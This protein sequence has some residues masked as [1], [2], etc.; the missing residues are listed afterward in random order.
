MAKSRFDKN[1]LYSRSLAPPKGSF[2]L[3][4]PRGCGKSTWLKE[5]FGQ[6]RLISLLDESLY[7]SYL[8]NPSLFYNSVRTE[9]PGSWVAVD[10]VQ[11]LPSLLNEVHRLI[12]DQKLKFV[13]TGSS[14]RKLRRTGVN[15]LAGRAVRRDMYPLTPMEMGDDFDLDQ[16]LKFGTLPLI[17][18]SEDPKDTLMSYVQMY[19]KE[20]IQAEA[21]VKNLSG[22][23][24][25]LPVAALF[26]GQ[27]LNMSNVARDAEV[28]R[29]TVKGFFDILEDTLLAKKLPAF[30]SRLR[31]REKSRSKFYWI[32]PG[33]VRAA[34]KDLN[35]VNAEEM[36]TLFEGFIHMLLCFQKDTYQDIDEIY[37]WSPAET[38]LTE[39]DFLLKKGREY[40]AIEVKSS[41][42]LRTEHLKGLRAISGL[43]GIK[44]K[45]L[46][47]LGAENLLIDDDIEVLNFKSFISELSKKNI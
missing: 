2:F 7:Q 6:A 47:Y 42:Q 18:K 9:K 4:G 28:Q 39:V 5:S 25:F 33:I 17:L 12:E 46:V 11:R 14:A 29:P 22:F 44:R 10:E 26:H 24:R 19:L 30:Q 23:S 20:E 3:F 40:I 1:H 38:K 15:L 16:A 41:R 31:V 36:G 35:E 34:R 43:K 8:A 27:I 13:L 32:D 45:V 21:I 37:Y